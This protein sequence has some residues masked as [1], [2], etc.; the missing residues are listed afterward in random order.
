MKS[1]IFYVGEFKK[2]YIDFFHF[3]RS[4]LILT[5]KKYYIQKYKSVCLKT[6][7]MH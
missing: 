5:T 3:K 2:S 6:S 7:E 4:D 1:R